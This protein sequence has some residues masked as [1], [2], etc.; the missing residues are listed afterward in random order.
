LRDSASKPVTTEGRIVVSEPSPLVVHGWRRHALVVEDDSEFCADL[1]AAL[2]REGIE[3][4]V[5]TTSLEALR[6]MDV[7]A[8]DLAVADVA[9]R[10]EDAVELIRKLRS[11]RPELP[12]LAI[13]EWGPHRDPSALHFAA[14]FGAGGV[15]EKPFGAEDLAIAIRRVLEPAG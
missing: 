8:V 1:R 4:V 2:E 5:A 6:V 3:V 11:R 9:L 14:A 13:A 15:L 12:I 7:L 10:E